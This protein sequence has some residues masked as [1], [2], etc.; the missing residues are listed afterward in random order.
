MISML[1]QERDQLVGVANE[2][3]IFIMDAEGNDASYAS[4]VADL[5]KEHQ[6]LAGKPDWS[7][8]DYVAGAG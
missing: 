8:D 7:K 4:D 5:P 2:T 6:V 1:E 3:N